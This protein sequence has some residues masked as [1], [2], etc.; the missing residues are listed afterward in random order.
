MAAISSK[1]TSCQNSQQFWKEIEKTPS[2]YDPEKEVIVKN[3]NF[4]KAKDLRSDM[5]W[6]C[7]RVEKYVQ[8]HF[9][10]RPKFVLDLGCGA[11]ANSFPFYYTL[12][13][14][15]T[16]IDS[17]LEQMLPFAVSTLPIE[18]RGDRLRLIK[19]DITKATSF[20]KEKY[21]IVIAVDILP[22]LPP[23]HLKKVMTLA[24]NALQDN[25]LLIGTIF[26]DHSPE[27]ESLM[28]QLGAHFYPG[29][30]K[31]VRNFLKYSD[32]EPVKIERRKEG[33][34]RFEAK[35]SK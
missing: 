3:I 4:G 28:S 23:K 30:E 7:Q 22:Y 13:S 24:R 8:S 14:F 17:S 19:Q 26:S 21:N 18:S 9:F 12:G 31:F 11:G 34:F 6:K 10:E 1:L 27:A 29:G 32:F 33:G 35:K 2:Q 15:V 5:F 25:G 16:A 20:G